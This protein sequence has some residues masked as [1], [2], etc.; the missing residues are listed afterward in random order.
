MNG[1][2]LRFY[3]HE[4]HRHNKKLAY[5]WLLEKASSIGSVN[6]S[7]FRAT[8]G[9]RSACDGQHNDVTDSVMDLTIVVEFILGNTEADELIS[10]VRQARLPVLLTRTAIEFEKLPG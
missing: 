3:I 5:E 4:N 1:I 9:F 7:V 8:A 10:T 6:G 2:C